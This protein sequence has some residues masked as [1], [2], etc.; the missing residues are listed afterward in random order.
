MKTRAKQIAG[1]TLPDTRYVILVDGGQQYVCK[2][3]GS[4]MRKLA[5]IVNTGKAAA[6]KRVA[7]E[8]TEGG[9]R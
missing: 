6:I 8:L 7:L 9:A 2:T 3:I 5:D 4:A 1:F